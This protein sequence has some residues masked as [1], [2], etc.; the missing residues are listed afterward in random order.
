VG[1]VNWIEGDYAAA[2]PF[3]ENAVR[4]ARELG[5]ASLVTVAVEHLANLSLSDGCYQEALAQY[6][7]ALAGRSDH[8]LKGLIPHCV[9]RVAGIAA[10][11]GEPHRAARLYGAMTLEQAVAYA[12]EAAPTDKHNAI[13]FHRNGVTNFSPMRL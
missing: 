10:R 1:F 13:F 6:R 9:R 5:S 8:S 7:E 3:L 2:R 11:Q 12:L 4:L